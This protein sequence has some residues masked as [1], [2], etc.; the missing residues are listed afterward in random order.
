MRFQVENHG[1]ICLIR[2]LSSRAAKWLR[3]TAPEEAQFLGKA[4]AVEPRYVYSVTE[5]IDAAGGKVYQ[6]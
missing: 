1:S 5:A 3:E 2:P 6:S 4:L